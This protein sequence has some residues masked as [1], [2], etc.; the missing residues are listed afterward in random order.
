MKPGVEW[1]DMHKLAETEILTGL[2]ELGLVSGDVAEMV[3]KRVCFYFMPHGLGH[4]IGLDTH[5]CGGYLDGYPERNP[6][7]G[8]KNVRTARVLEEGMVIT[9]EP[10]C[11]FISFLL[12]NE[13]GL[14]ID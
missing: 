4:F 6:L 5:D 2:K 7:P 12:A 8:L 9:V 3:E 14:D 10:G 1:L 11:Y 13:P